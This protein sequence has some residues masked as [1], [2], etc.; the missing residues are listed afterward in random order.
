M[1]DY[2]RAQVGKMVPA[3]ECE[4]EPV[5]IV[6]DTALRPGLVRKSTVLVCKT[7]GGKKDE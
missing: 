2:F 7:C 5:K 1:N 4:Y 3:H 6:Q